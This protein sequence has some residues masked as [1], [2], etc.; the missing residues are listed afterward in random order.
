MANQYHW[1]SAAWFERVAPPSTV[2]TIYGFKTD[3]LNVRTIFKNAERMV[4]RVLSAA[5]SQSK[6]AGT[7]RRLLKT[8]VKLRLSAGFQQ[9]GKT[10]RRKTS[11]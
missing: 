5:L 6:A 3:K 1:C 2:K 7:R 4:R 9:L 10:G 11:E 8:Y